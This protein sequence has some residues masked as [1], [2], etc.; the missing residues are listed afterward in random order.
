MNKDDKLLSA[1]DSKS[2]RRS[3]KCKLFETIL[4]KAIWLKK[5]GIT[6]ETYDQRILNS[7][8]D[9]FHQHLELGCFCVVRSFTYI[10]LAT[11]YMER[12]YSMFQSCVIFMNEHENRLHKTAQEIRMEKEKNFINDLDFKDE[13]SF[14][15][16]NNDIINVSNF[17]KLIENL[18][19]ALQM[20]EKGLQYGKKESMLNATFLDR[21]GILSNMNALFQIFSYY[22]LDTYA[23][24]VMNL[25]LSIVDQYYSPLEIRNEDTMLIQ[26][27]LLRI[28]LKLGFVKVASSYY[29]RFFGHIKFL[30]MDDI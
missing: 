24:K 15:A 7:T 14:I 4:K 18:I 11:T 5:Q 9:N 20:F 10:A 23:L 21:F 29:K 30:E 12:F 27:N 3:S 16:E 22:N 19:N 26:C 2:S 6:S 13:S 25:S 28:L 8:I 1:G 17:N